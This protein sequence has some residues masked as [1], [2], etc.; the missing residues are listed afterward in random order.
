MADLGIIPKPPAVPQNGAAQQAPPVEE[1]RGPG[2]P[3]GSS[4]PKES[5]VRP[6][7]TERLIATKQELE[8][9]LVGAGDDHE[10]IEKIAD[11]QLMV[12]DVE[13][14]LINRRKLLPKKP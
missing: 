2:R 12:S 3:A 7:S 6:V 9:L 8:S 5:N 14:M 11:L 13:R 4:S 10:L 1:K